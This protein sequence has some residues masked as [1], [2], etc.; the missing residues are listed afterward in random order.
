MAPTLVR[1]GV[2]LALVAPAWLLANAGW[3]TLGASAGTLPV[4]EQL[5]CPPPPGPGWRIDN[6]AAFR[7]EI[8]P[9]AGSFLAV[10]QY[11]R[12]D[13]FA[14]VSMSVSWWPGANPPT[15][16]AGFCGREETTTPTTALRRSASKAAYVQVGDSTARPVGPNQLLTAAQ[17]LLAQAEQRAAACAPSAGGL[18]CPQTLAGIPFSTFG[19]GGSPSEKPGGG[20]FVLLCRYVAPSGAVANLEVEWDQA[21]K[22]PHTACG[23]PRLDT[24]GGGVPSTVIYSQTKAAHLTVLGAAASVTDMVRAGEPLLAA[25]EP[26]AVPCP[27]RPGAAVPTVAAA[28]GTGTPAEGAV[29]D[30]ELYREGTVPDEGIASS[31]LEPGSELP[32][33]GE[34]AA[35]AA[36]ATGVVAAGAAVQAARSGR[37]R[38]PLGRLPG[39]VE[40]RLVS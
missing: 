40:D 35:A 7:G 2:V 6:D 37:R 22:T 19:G 1:F 4:I 36:A 38:G 5:Q 28:G 34:A 9:G 23:R 24:T 3:G 10:C 11:E 18:S 15:G 17:P 8:V 27:E 30:D 14:T 33:G 13:S 39:I 31:V 12:D 16:P 29:G 21:A 25:V 32:S 26:L 20:T